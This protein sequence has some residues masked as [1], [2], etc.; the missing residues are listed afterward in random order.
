MRIT[1]DKYRDIV[2][3]RVIDNIYS[4]ASPLSE[5]HIVHVNS[6]Y[7]GGG[8][9]EILNSLVLLM[10]QVGIPTGWRLLKGNPDFFNVTKKIHNSLQGANINLSKMK[11]R[12]YLECNELNS[13]FTHIGS[14]DCVIVHD[15]QPLPI[16]TFYKKKQPWI[17]RCH[18]DISHPNQLLWDYLKTFLLQYDMMIVS[19]DK[20]KHGINIPQRVIRP[21]I[22]PLSYKNKRLIE[23]RIHSTLS[24]Q[25]IETDKPII[26]QVSR[27]DKWKDPLGVIQAYRLIK[28]KVDCRLVLLGAMAADDPEGQKLYEKVV[29]V[30][31]RYKDILVINYESDILVNAL[32]RVSSVVI[33][34]SLKEG[35][36]LTVS[37][38]LWKGTPVVGGRVGGIPAQIKH[39]KNGYLVNS[40]PD[41]AKRVIKVLKNQDLAERMGAFGHEYVQDHFLITRHLLDY[42]KL[43]KKIFRK[44]R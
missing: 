25:G 37:E 36:A 41:C 27:F 19:M 31:S 3:D 5:K 42:I 32:Q 15:P 22:D 33:Q 29:K 2:G 9:V 7:Y 12:V 6:T 21:S 10:N 35:F 18:I 43:L 26:S 11:K 44:K 40:V 16:I 38:A 24:D 1:L 4:E 8:V 20:F 14:H 30:A 13:F 23:K 17:W 39:G 28:K 34:K